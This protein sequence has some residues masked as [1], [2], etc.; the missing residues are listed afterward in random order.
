MFY[1][2]QLLTSI[3]Y[4]L[5]NE[6][7]IFNNFNNSN[8]FYISTNNKTYTLPDFFNEYLPMIM[9]DEGESIIGCLCFKVGIDN[10][11]ELPIDKI[12]EHIDCVGNKINIRQE[13]PFKG[14]TSENKSIFTYLKEK[15]EN[16]SCNEY[17]IKDDGSGEIAD[18]IVITNNEVQF[19]HCKASKEATSGLRIKEFYEVIGQAIK[20]SKWIRNS[21]IF[22]QLIKRINSDPERLIKGDLNNLKKLK[23]HHYN[24]KIYVVQ[25]GLDYVKF[26]NKQPADIKKLIALG[27]DVIKSNG[28]FKV[29]CNG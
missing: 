22:N 13:I 16:E 5:N 28:E 21:D 9:T 26:V 19:Y 6:D 11:K 1:N 23:A 25:P 15:F 7:T 20:S 3:L 18:F 17:I 24:Y 2:E 14:E 8:E 12:F 4:D 27:Y 29:I 10:S